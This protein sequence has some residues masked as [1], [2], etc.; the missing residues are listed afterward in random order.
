MIMTVPVLMF[1]IVRVLMAVLVDVPVIMNRAV[2]MVV[3]M[4]MPVIVV[5]IVLMIFHAVSYYGDPRA[6]NAVT[7]VLRDLQSPSFCI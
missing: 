5:M 6:C 7:L 1:I 3:L 2:M 4:V